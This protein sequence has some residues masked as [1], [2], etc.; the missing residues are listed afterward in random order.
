MPTRDTEPAELAALLERIAR[1]DAAAYAEF[2]DRT[3]ARV[4]G[5]VLRVLR[6]RGYSE[7]TTQEVYLQVW[8]EAA[9]YRRTE[10]SPI[11]WLIAIAHRRAVD[12]VRAETAATRRDLTYGARQV[13]ALIDEVGEEVADREAAG[14][15]R[16]CLGR[17][18]ERQA[19]A[20]GL[21]YYEGLTYS[22]VADR[23]AV[24]LPTVKSRI[25]DGLKRLRGCLDGG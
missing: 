21:A 11:A 13:T 14:L 2:Y 24:A 6:D 20:V 25:R 7:E 12:R 10:G 22:E 8:R 5:M 18:T 17:L 19:E 3:G 1:S 15:V 9:A 16:R 23:L 4:F